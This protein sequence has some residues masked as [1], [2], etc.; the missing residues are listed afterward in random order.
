MRRFE[1]ASLPLAGL[2]LLERKRMG[3]ERGF[4]SRIFCADELAENGWHKPIAQINHACTRKKGAVRGLHFQRPP[5]AEMKLVSVIRGELWD[6]AIDLR[7]GSKTYL[8]WHAEILSSENNRAMLIPEGFAHG[9]QAMTA[10]VEVLY[11]HSAAYNKESECGLNPSDVTL[12]IKWPVAISELSLRDRN[13]PLV[14]DG[15][16][17][18]SL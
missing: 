10:D 4:L 13:H 14:E 6:V 11:C 1:S 18:L 16:V 7:E 12:G 15:F 3:D 17:G 2:K 9:Y 8:Q 5:H